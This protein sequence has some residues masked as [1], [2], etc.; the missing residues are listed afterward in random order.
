MPVYDYKCDKCG[1]VQE[2]FHKLDEELTEGCEN[3]NCEGEAA[4]L[5]RQLNPTPKHGSWS[6]WSV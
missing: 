6:R 5:K 2:K 4:D 3:P 1:M